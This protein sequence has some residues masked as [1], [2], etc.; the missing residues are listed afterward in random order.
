MLVSAAAQVPLPWSV[1]APDTDLLIM[2]RELE[3][4]SISFFLIPHP[5]TT[6][7]TTTLHHGHSHKRHRYIL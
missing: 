7:T 6:I 4:H 5:F 1:D 2:I 3:I